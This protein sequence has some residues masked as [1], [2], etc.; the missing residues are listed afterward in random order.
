M[1]FSHQ[2][3]IVTFKTKYKERNQKSDRRAGHYPC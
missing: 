3:P 1:F 2:N